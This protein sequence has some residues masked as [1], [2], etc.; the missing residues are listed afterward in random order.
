MLPTSFLRRVALHCRVYQFFVVV[1]ALANS[2]SHRMA[3]S[4]ILLSNEKHSP[5]DDISPEFCR[6]FHLDPSCGPL[7]PQKNHGLLPT[8]MVLSPSFGKTSIQTV[9]STR[10]C[11]FALR[12]S[13]HLEDCEASA[14]YVMRINFV[15]CANDMD[16]EAAHEERR[17]YR[18][19]VGQ[20][21]T[22]TDHRKET[23]SPTSNTKPPS[24]ARWSPT[25][26]T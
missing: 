10:F 15:H 2:S 25:F 23:G 17:G 11:V 22:M 3:V 1:P 9:C 24:M 26:T 13:I 20:P 6:F 14:L 21:Q 12:G 16:D 8:D 18:F 4:I 5:N 7:V 19:G